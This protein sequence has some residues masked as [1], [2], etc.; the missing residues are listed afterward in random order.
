MYESNNTWKCK[1]KNYNL[2]VNLPNDLP[3]T[4][5]S[6]CDFRLKLIPTEWLQNILLWNNAANKK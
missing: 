3:T 2:E 4:A 1:Y 6:E 5:K